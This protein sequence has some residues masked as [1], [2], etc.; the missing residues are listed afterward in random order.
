MI[1]K[2]RITS[3]LNKVDCR[4][5]LVSV[6]AKRARELTEGEKELVEAKTSCT[7]STAAEEL[8]EGKILYVP[9][10]AEQIK[11]EEEEANN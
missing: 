8:D 3:L 10:T 5:V 6:V 11:Q 1:V 4:Y 9:K 7:V 2:P